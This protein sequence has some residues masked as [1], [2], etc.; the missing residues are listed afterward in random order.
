MAEGKEARILTLMQFARKAG[1]LIHGTE[2]CLRAALRHKL[3]LLIIAGDTASR[4]QT[5]VQNTLKMNGVSVPTIQLGTQDD[6]SNAL[7]LPAT[8]V[9]GV[10]D[11][12]F[13]AKIQEYHTS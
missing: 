11:R 12:Q 13:A 6:L 4:T 7:G 5:R 3:S 2:A 8:G 9:F 10:A 1:K